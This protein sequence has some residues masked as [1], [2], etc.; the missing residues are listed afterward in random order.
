MSA[1][2]LGFSFAPTKVAKLLSVLGFPVDLEKALAELHEV[3]DYSDALMFL[4]AAMVL[5]LY[6]GLLEPVSF[7]CAIKKSQF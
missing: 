3:T 2:S 7:Q 5:L 4:P 1:T 6:Y